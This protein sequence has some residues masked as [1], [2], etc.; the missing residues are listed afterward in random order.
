MS[1]G[2]SVGKKNKAAN[3]FAALLH[4]AIEPRQIAAFCASRSCRMRPLAAIDDCPAQPPDALLL[5]SRNYKAVAPAPC[6]AAPLTR[7]GGAGLTGHLA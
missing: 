6:A 3:V 1:F 2:R 7:Y 5:T 4:L